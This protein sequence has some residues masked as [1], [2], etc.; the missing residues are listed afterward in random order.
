[1][2]QRPLRKAETA[3]PLPPRRTPIPPPANDN[4]A[5]RR[6]AMLLAALTG[7]AALVAFLLLH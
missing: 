1:M 6:W 3:A 7:V 4:R 2:A 5:R